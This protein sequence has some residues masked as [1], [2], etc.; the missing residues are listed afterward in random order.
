MESQAI[1]YNNDIRIKAQPKQAK[2]QLDFLFRNKNVSTTVSSNPK[3]ISSDLFNHFPGSAF[4]LPCRTFLENRSTIAG[5]YYLN[6]K[7]KNLIS[8]IDQ[9]TAY[10]VDNTTNYGHSFAWIS[11]REAVENSRL[12]KFID[13]GKDFG[14]DHFKKDKILQDVKKAIEAVTGFAG[15]FNDR[16][17]Y[18]FTVQKSVGSEENIL[19]FSQLSSG[20]QHF[21]SFVASLAVFL[22]TNFPE[23]ENPMLC[24][25]VFMIDA[26]ELHL[27]PYWQ[28][29]IIPK[30]LTSFPKCQFIITT[31]SPQVLGNVK[32]DSVFILK[33]EKDNIVYEKPDESYGMTM[34]HLLEL[35]M[36]E[37]SRPA[38][39]IRK[40]MEILFE[41]IS[42]KKHDDAFQLLKTLKEK[43]PT[44]PDLARAEMLIHRKGIKL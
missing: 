7:T 21:V 30:L 10:I 29:K 34:N 25:A 20:E 36:D 33:R 44:D 19:L 12:R 11:E 17:K 14:K 8:G 16:E 22:V 42:R 24:E 5:T 39:D 2:I 27:H 37:E 3:E 23:S 1:I 38:E 18:E 41:N 26:I 4:W 40:Q 31:H 43:I 6:E 28:R 13:S 35:V 9:T 32:R 15:L